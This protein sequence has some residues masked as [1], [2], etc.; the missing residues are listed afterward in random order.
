MDEIKEMLA[1]E[2]A[3]IDG[4]RARGLCPACEEPSRDHGSICVHCGAC[5]KQMER[6]RACGNCGSCF[7]GFA[8][9]GEDP[10]PLCQPEAYTPEM[11]ERARSRYMV[12]FE[13]RRPESEG[14]SSDT[15]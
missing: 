4:L 7:G 6:C 12:G 5:E 1:E 9:V 2:G 15:R 14:A 3:R 13:K 10:C 8:M 11:L